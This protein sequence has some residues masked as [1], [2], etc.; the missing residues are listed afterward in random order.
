MRR[1]GHSLLTAL[2][3]RAG[4]ATAVGLAGFGFLSMAAAA[5]KLPSAPPA[6]A[7]SNADAE[8][9]FESKV[10]PVL[11]ERC[12]ACHGEKNQ[13]G[14]LR[15]DSR[16]AMLQG[17]ATGPSLVPGSPDRSTLI[18]AVR[19][20]GRLKMPPTGRL[21]P[22]EVELLTRWV[23]QGAAWPTVARRETAGKPWAF[24]PVRK[25]SI[26]TVKNRSWIKTPIDAF[27]LAELEK[28]G[29][30]PAPPADRRT[31]IR[32][33]SYDLTG[34]PPSPEEVE[35]FVNDRAPDAF[36]KVI[37]KLLSSP[38]Y[39]ERWGRHWLDVARYADSRDARYVGAD[40]DIADA[41]R[42]RDWV[43]KA[44][45][46]DLPYNQ[47]IIDQIAGDLVPGSGAD[48]FNADGL[49]ATG[50][51]SIGE[52]GT[53]DADKEKMMTDIV[54]DQIN[55]VSRAFMGLTISCARCHDHKF[56]PIS[57]KD[58]YGLAGIF[59][60][61]HILPSPGAKTAGSALLRSPLLPPSELARIES[62]KTRI[63]ELEKQL[64]AQRE[65]AYRTHARSLLPQ[66]GKYLLAA[67]DY[68]HQPS[69]AARLSLPN[70]AE[71]Q[72][73]QPSLLRQWLD[74]LGLSDYRLMTTLEANASG[75]TGVRVWRGGRDCPNLLVNRTDQDVSIL[76]YKLPA[77][78]VS[79]HPGPAGGVVARW[80]SPIA[81]NV[82]IAGRVADADTACG[83]GIAW[84]VQA[85]SDAGGM[86]L[87]K[88]E[89]PNAGGQ[90]LTQGATPE[91][92]AEVSVRPGDEIDLQ[93]LPKG[94]YSCD[95]TTVEL[96]ITLP[97]GKRWDLTQDLVTSGESADGN[98]HADRYGNPG[99]WSF[100]D[101]AGSAGVDRAVVEAE[102]AGWHQTA[103]AVAAGSATRS[104]LERA[105]Q[106]VGARFS[107]VD[108][109][110]PFWIRDAAD[111]RL[112]P[113]AVRTE[114]AGVAGELDRLKKEPA[115]ALQ[116]AL[117]AREGG[118]PG[119]VHEGIHDAK[120]HIR[121]NYLRLGEVVPR[122]FPVVLAGVSQPPI[123]KGSGRLPLAQW[124]ARADHPLTGR[125]LVNRVWEY[126]FGEGIVRTPNNFG[127]LGER[128]THPELL[129]WLAAT[130]VGGEARG[131]GGE[132][133]TR[134]LPP[135]SSPLS[136]V[137]P[138]SIKSLHRLI[139]LSSTYQQASVAGPQTLKAD[140]DNRL[141]GRF[142][143]RRLEAEEVRDAMLAV[144]GRLDQTMGGLAT[145]DF[146]NPR[147]T[148]Y[149]MAIRSDRS[150]FRPLFDA[151]DP[152]T[153][154]DR[155]T[156]STVAPQALFLL[157]HPFAREQ[158]AALAERLK[159]ESP[160]GSG[161]RIRR[162][163]GLLYGRQPS[164]EEL[165][166]GLQFV[167]GTEAEVDL[168]WRDYCQ[169]LMCANEFIYVD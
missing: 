100:L 63:A 140:P 92:L 3:T 164:A 101:M 46:Q 97:G 45:N 159:K 93:V 120:V 62:R 83:N 114:L 60:S 69:G 7:G 52:W 56:D 119:S 82:R 5:P 156:V 73:L 84:A 149:Q 17:G 108:A 98:P 36:A 18:Q 106:E 54:D 118:V 137:Q 51:L 71:R 139:M 24:Q 155:R 110:S 169:L 37:E 38:Q 70:F 30:R 124:L 148:L 58:Y 55:V 79:M 20:A 134:L 133:R 72:G 168:A 104:D 78:S 94:E 157:N 152:E 163:Y 127:K 150:G 144:S 117:A 39:G 109:R 96:T 33:A 68:S 142:S 89:I 131:E 31:L 74:F 64:K 146:M 107:L 42:Y 125:V 153:S 14:K 113:D 115:P 167:A 162:A 105:A 102:L 112:L 129:D 43:V 22:D 6:R 50:L 34:L 91:R 2:P 80:T 86:I 44:F 141:W 13:Y 35:A 130:F 88:G 9:F 48:G 99:V 161:E 165:R 143:R 47:F 122:R 25:P 76:T 32:R 67:W 138:W 85:R 41:W 4:I 1:S 95:T 21:R 116:Y 75:K 8:A 40:S 29:L 111:D 15:L 59:F 61:T 28:K 19:Y 154:V 16:S 87:S 90:L 57:T 135:H 81:G 27:V 65:E 121:G 147:R 23:Q 166:I 103:A 49:V 160:A 132:G 10:R 11:V 128:P 53:G 26:P 123:T 145:R 126:H 158:S 66:T 12:I 136:T 151:A 77:K